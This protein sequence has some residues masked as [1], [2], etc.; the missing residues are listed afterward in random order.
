MCW[1]DSAAFQYTSACGVIRY[2]ASVVPRS[3]KPMQENPPASP[4]RP[5][6][7]PPTLAPCAW[8]PSST[9]GSPRR[10]PIAVMAGMSA[11]CPWMCTGRI[12][13]ERG[14]ARGDHHAMPD[15]L[16]AGDGLFGFPDDRM[17]FAETD[18]HPFFQETHR[19]RDRALREA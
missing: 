3:L 18:G 2:P 11:G 13:R 8:L 6:A 14:V 5:T 10:R 16:P 1:E 9:T 15:H 19:P 12:A 4:Q 7:F 17:V